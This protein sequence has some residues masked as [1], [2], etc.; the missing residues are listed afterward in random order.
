MCLGAG[1]WRVSCC[2]GVAAVA[3]HLSTYLLVLTICCLLA[4]CCCC[5][6]MCLQAGQHQL[7]G[8]F[9]ACL[10]PHMALL[11]CSTSSSKSCRPSA[12]QLTHSC[13]MCLLC[14]CC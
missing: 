13:T 12:Q 3:A 4:L 6:S 9:A 10:W 11:D 14:C 5:V 1:P 8:E 7:A 2:F